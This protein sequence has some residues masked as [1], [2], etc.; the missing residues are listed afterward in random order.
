M[1]TPFIAKTILGIKC[2][3]YL[4]ITLLIGIYSIGIAR[5][6]A[7]SLR[8]ECNFMIQNHILIA[9]SPAVDSVSVEINSAFENPSE[10][11]LFTTK[12]Q[13]VMEGQIQLLKGINRF[14]IDISELPEGK[15]HLFISNSKK[16]EF[17]GHKSIHKILACN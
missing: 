9:P 12:G 14:K 4:V 10:I 1:H 16:V 8:T 15:Y 5:N 11:T 17:E 2:L 3:K 13:I 6:N 7:T